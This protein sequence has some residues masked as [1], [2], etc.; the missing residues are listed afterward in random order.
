MEIGA[1]VWPV[2][3]TCIQTSIFIRESTVLCVRLTMRGNGNDS[4]L[5][6]EMLMVN[7]AHAKYL[8]ARPMYGQKYNSIACRVWTR[9]FTRPSVKD[10]PKDGPQ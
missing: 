6:I 7:G 3:H 10:Q 8:Y 4:N 5:H 2:S 9:L 1:V